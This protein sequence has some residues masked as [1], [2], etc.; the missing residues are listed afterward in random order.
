[1]IL[2]YAVDET[3]L[4]VIGGVP[5]TSS[6]LPFGW[7]NN[8]FMKTNS[9]KS[10]FI[11]SCKETMKSIIDGLS[12]ES[13]KTEVI[14]G[15]KLKLELALKFEEFFNLCKKGQKLNAFARI[16]PFMNT[17]KMRNILKVFA[18]SQFSY[19]PLTWMFHSRG[20]FSDNSSSFSELLNKDNSVA[21]YHRDIR[22]LA[23]ETYKNCT[24]TFSTTSPPRECIYDLCVNKFLER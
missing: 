5:E 10:Y 11:M 14:L 8:N 6:S 19:Y 21:L 1:M 22:S 23:I 7:L 18:E 17:N 9:G 3:N 24:G 13:N 4:P 16:V 15:I 12:I 2:C 20:T